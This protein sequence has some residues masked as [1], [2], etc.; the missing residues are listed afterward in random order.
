MVPTPGH[1]DQPLQEWNHLQSYDTAKECEQGIVE[2]YGRNERSRFVLK[3][4]TQ[5]Q[6][7]SAWLAAEC[8]D[9]DDPRVK[10]N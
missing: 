3:G 4:F 9:T 1:K 10:G 5:A 8:I 2:W 6:V 7:K